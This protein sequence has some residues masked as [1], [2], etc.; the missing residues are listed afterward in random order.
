MPTTT[1]PRSG[2]RPRRPATRLRGTPSTGLA[3]C[4]DPLGPCQRQSRDRP[5]LRT[6]HDP[7]IDTDATFTGAGGLSFVAG[8]DHRLYAVFHAYRGTGPTS[9]TIRV[10]WAYRVVHTRHGYRLTEF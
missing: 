10:G 4:H 9:D 5:W 6:S 8:P 2:P 1:A 3:I 7:S